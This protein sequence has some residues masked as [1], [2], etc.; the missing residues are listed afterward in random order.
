MRRLQFGILGS[1]FA[2]LALSVLLAGC[3][4]DK[5]KDEGELTQTPSKTKGEG[6]KKKTGGAFKLVEGKGTA[7]LKGKITVKGG[8]APAGVLDDLTKSIQEQI[9]KKPDDKATCLA[10]SPV[11]VSQQ[12]YRIGGNKN[13]GNVVVWLAPPD[14]NTVFKIDEKQAAEAKA[15]PGEIDQPHCAFLPHVSTL[16]VSYR[17]PAN[18]KNTVETGQTLTVHNSAKIAHNT[19][20]SGGTD[21]PKGN[22]LIPP[23]GKVTITDL[24]PDA[25]LPLT[26]KCNIHGWMDGFVW[27]FDHPYATVSRSDTAPKGLDVKESDPTFGTYEIK[28]VPAGTKLRVVAWHEKGGFLNGREGEEIELKEG[29]NEK[30]FELEV[31]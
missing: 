31:K 7:T 6:P 1:T 16:F 27:I 10:G 5:D 19:N 11:E 25:K 24:V 8:A 26:I 15:H 2:A 20:W 9:A 18:P 13:V 21:E 12:T 3:S 23:G 29:D 30:N 4:K 28:G 14:R 22:Q 17:D